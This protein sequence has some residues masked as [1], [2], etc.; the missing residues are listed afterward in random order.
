MI[1]NVKK[2]ILKYIIRKNKKL[3]CGVSTLYYYTHARVRV[4]IE[5]YNIG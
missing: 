3:T 1:L 5:Y 2:I 4:N